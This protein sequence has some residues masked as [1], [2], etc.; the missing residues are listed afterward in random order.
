MT[1]PQDLVFLL[2]IENALLDND[3][4]ELD[5]R[6]HQSD[7][8][9]RCAAGMSGSHWQT[10]SATSSISASV[11]PTCSMF[12]RSD[13]MRTCM[14]ATYCNREAPTSSPWTREPAGRV[15]GLSGPARRRGHPVST[16][17]REEVG[18]WQ[19]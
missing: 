2:D 3:W 11:G 14:W 10:P 1:P 13:V 15:P 9:V 5:L 4:I 16:P 18:G 7:Q 12:S 8:P 6:P 17:L 19:P